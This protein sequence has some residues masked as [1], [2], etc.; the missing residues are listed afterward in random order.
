MGI[1]LAAQEFFALTKSVVQASD[2]RVRKALLRIEPL[3]RERLELAS[4]ESLDFFQRVGEGLL[5][6]RGYA[7]ADLRTSCLKACGYYLFLTGRAPEA[8]SF[9]EQ[10]LELARRSSRPND[11]RLFHTLLGAL[12]GEIGAT[13]DAIQSHQSALE[14]TI[15]LSDVQGEIVCWNNLSALLLD[16]GMYVE[17]ISAARRAL[18]LLDEVDSDC[19][20]NRARCETNLALALHR[21]GELESALGYAL[22][23]ISHS[24]EPQ[25]GR[26]AQSKIIR[27]CNLAGILIDMGEIRRAREHAVAASAL[28]KRY[29]NDRSAALADVCA[30]LV[31]VFGGDSTQGI[32]RL[33]EV[34]RDKTVMAL[35]PLYLNSLGALVRAYRAVER[36]E[37]ALHCLEMLLDQISS[38]HVKSIVDQLAKFVDF[39]GNQQFRFSS[40]NLRF[41]QMEVAVLR[42]K[43]AEGQVQQSRLEMLE[44]MAIAADIREDISG[45]H[46]FR[47][48]RLSALLAR[49]IGWD[50]DACN[51]LDI[52]A[53][54]HDIGKIGI[55]EKILLDEKTLREAEKQFIA[56]HTKVGA[57]ILSRSD[58]PQ[59]RIAEEIARCHH[60]W[61][62]GGGYPKHLKGKDI[63][64]S[65]RIVA[66][67]DVFDAMTHGRPYAPA[68]PIEEALDLIA[69][70]RGRQFDPELTDHFLALVRR[71][72]KENE[73]L[74]AYLGKAARNSPFLKARARIKELLAQG[75]ETGGLSPS[76]RPPGVSLN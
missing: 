35:P 29:P 20:E 57:E 40:A 66:L 56:S 69:G 9:A 34:S 46:G 11:A 37:E 51:A 25:N 10:G 38:K 41:H 50:R 31:E 30:A 39:G 16:A 6:L 65:A 12:L 75:G 47:V 1:H 24:H 53:R 28:S 43:V 15:K 74:D 62:D 68:R 2:P 26:Q 14:L 17:S 61:W 76:P 49:E 3:A 71:L 42:Q 45:E 21:M 5:R 60:E 67:A 54:L 27:E 22:M 36:N 63:P 19:N 52:A 44:R 23:S 13:A 64:R 73:N 48:G 58:I 7:Q 4:A 32:L 8:F 18:R 33:E 70:L 59:V 55:P 72:A